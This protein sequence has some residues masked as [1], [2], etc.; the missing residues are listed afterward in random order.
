MSWP[1]GSPYYVLP[2]QVKITPADIGAVPLSPLMDLTEIHAAWIRT[3]RKFLAERDGFVP[4]V[5]VA[6]VPGG[7]TTPGGG[8]G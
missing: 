6:A 4:P 8:P 7:R 2:N 5:V 3:Y 1:T